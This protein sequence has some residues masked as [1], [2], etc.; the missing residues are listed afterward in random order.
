MRVGAKVVQ[1]DSPQ[2][3]IGEVVALHP[4][5]GLVAVDWWLRGE[6]YKTL[7]RPG[8]LDAPRPRAVAP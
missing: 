4:E 8:V 3:G 1:P 7:E 5:W 2:L 6:P